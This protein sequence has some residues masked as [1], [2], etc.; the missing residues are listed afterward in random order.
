[1]Y[2]TH[3]TVAAGSVTVGTVVTYPLDTLKT[4]IQV[5]LC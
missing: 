4:I 3:A 5:L 1:M 2:A